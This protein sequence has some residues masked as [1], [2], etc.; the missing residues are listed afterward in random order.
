VM[1]TVGLTTVRLGKYVDQLPLPV[2]VRYEAPLA[3]MST[4]QVDVEHQLT[5]YLTISGMAHS[6][7]DLYGLGLGL[8]REFR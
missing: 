1:G 6:T 2:W 8:K 7:H 4:G 5:R 3:G